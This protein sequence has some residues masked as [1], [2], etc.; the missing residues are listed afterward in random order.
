VSA[1]T[2]VIGDIHGDLDHLRTLIERLPLITREDTVVFL[3]DYLDRGPH[4]REVVRVVRALD[5]E[6]GCNVIALRGNHEDAWLRVIDRGWPEFVMPP[7]NGCLATFQSYRDPARSDAMPSPEESASIFSG[8]F[9]PADV[10]DWMRSLPLFHEDEHGIYVHAGLIEKDG[11]F[12]HPSQTE[13]KS[14]LLWTRS[15]AFFHDYRGKR[16]V[17]GHTATDLLPQELSQHTPED[18]T[19]MWVSDHVIAI[20][21]QCGKGGFLTAVELPS[22][23]V[24]ESR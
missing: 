19:D 6:L 11:E 16:V 3:G 14:A 13:P 2:F 4:S 8:G 22:L 18:P 10:V 12:L 17:I 23:T 1:R 24:Y 20:D 7:S 21:T 15:K 5:L 9:F